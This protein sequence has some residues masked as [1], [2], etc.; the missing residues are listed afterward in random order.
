MSLLRRQGFTVVEIAVCVALLAALLTLLGKTLAAVEVHSR[1]TDDRAREMRTLENML[2]RMLLGSWDSIDEGRIRSLSLPEELLAQW[3]RASL[4]GSVT[5]VSDPVDGKR[6]TLR[7]ATGG[8]DRERPL[9]LTTW[10][11]R[12]PGEVENVRD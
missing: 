9:T 6:V 10:I 4:E 3:P 12:S 5:A 1:Q 7:L 8:D 11:Y 2:E